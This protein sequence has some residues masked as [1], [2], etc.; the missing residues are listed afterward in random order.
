MA[1]LIIGAEAK[2]HEGEERYSPA[3]PQFN[4]RPGLAAFLER[5]TKRLRLK[6][7]SQ[8]VP[9][10]H[11]ENGSGGAPPPGAPP[12]A[13]LRRNGWVARVAPVHV[14]S[15]T[16]HHPERLGTPFSGFAKVDVESSN[17]FSRSVF[18]IFGRPNPKILLG[19]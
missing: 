14:I 12:R 5:R 9:G 3:A 2:R 15:A 1:K 17:L 13:P 7:S 8:R 11:F 19:T 4:D 16:W 6:I 18:L 10:G